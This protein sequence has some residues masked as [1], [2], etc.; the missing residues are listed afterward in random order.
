[1]KLFQDI[2]DNTYQIVQYKTKDHINNKFKLK[3]P[4]FNNDTMN[5]IIHKIALSFD[6]SELI[7]SEAIFAFIQKKQINPSKL[8]DLEKKIIT[9]KVL[10]E[11]VNKMPKNENMKYFTK[12]NKKILERE[13]KSGNKGLLWIRQ[14]F[15]DYQKE[16]KEVIVKELSSPELFDQIQCITHDFEEDISLNIFNDTKLDS[17]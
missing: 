4:I 17:N 13:I 8:L 2:I 1:M 15:K 10:R 6:P 14:I 3:Y 16:Y 11:V 5:D 7:T 12:Q 9:N